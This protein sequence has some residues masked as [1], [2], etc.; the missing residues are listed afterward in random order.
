M[1]TSI[2]RPRREWWSLLCARRCSVSSLMRSVSSATWT[3]A[4]P[5][6][7]SS[8]PYLPISSCFFSLVSAHRA[9]EQRLARRSRTRRRAR[10]ASLDVAAASARPASSTLVEALLAAQPGDERDPQGLAVEVAV[11]VDQVGLD[12][13]PA[14]GL[15]GRPH[16][17]VD[18]RRVA[19][20]ERG[21]D[22]VAGDTRRSSGTRLAV[23][24]PS[25]R[26]RWSPSTTV[27]L[28]QERRAEA[29]RRAP[30]RRRRRPAPGSGSRRRSRRR[31]RP[32]A[33]PG[34][35]T[36]RARASISGSPF[37]LAPK[38][39]FSPTETCSAPSRSTRTRSMKSSAAI[40]ARTRS[41][42]GITTSSST[43]RPVDH[44][45][46]DLERHDQLRRRLRVDDRA[47]GAA[48]R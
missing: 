9:S 29:A 48:R 12:Q 11:E 18:G 28:E 30:R 33:R 4:E 47:A 16:A 5:V 2:S 42:N 34:S 35:R 8:R 7:P 23:G 17:D 21:V 39:K 20:G 44:V 22:A 14:A 27:A 3:S 41:S 26:P 40:A 46:L 45:A 6:S 43:P 19:V 1:P 37:A 32:A 25:S 24:K 31:P 38:R 36:R 13:H 10:R 15:E